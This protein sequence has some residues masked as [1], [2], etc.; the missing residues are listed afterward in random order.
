[1]LEQITLINSKY[2]EGVIT[3]SEF[4]SSLKNIHF[5]SFS[6]L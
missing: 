6:N 3:K 1:V 2:M 5:S 4:E